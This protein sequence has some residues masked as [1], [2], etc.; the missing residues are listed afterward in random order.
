[1]FVTQN[2]DSKENLPLDSVNVTLA[3]NV[4]CFLSISE[5]VFRAGRRMLKEKRTTR[6]VFYYGNRVDFLNVCPCDKF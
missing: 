1:M 3:V 2:A 4:S 6:S 5:S